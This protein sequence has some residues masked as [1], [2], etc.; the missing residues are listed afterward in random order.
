MRAARLHFLSST[1]R[2]PR[3]IRALASDH[4]FKV[5]RAETLMRRPIRR[6]MAP[7]GRLS[8]ETP[9]PL[10]VLDKARNILNARGDY[11][12][13]GL[14]PRAFRSFKSGFMKPSAVARHASIDETEQVIV[15][16]NSGWP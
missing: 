15:Q 11:S 12:Q 4:D 9:V 8:A 1:L 3:E 10:W 5:A 6:R 7:Q 2:S 14:L 16:K 13:W